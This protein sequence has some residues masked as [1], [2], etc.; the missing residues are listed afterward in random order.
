MQPLLQLTYKPT[1]Q[2]LIQ[3]SHSVTLFETCFFNQTELLK[4]AFI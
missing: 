2:I 1:I 4:L 3:L